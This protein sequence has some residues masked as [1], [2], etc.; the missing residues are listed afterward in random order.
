MGEVRNTLLNVYIFSGDDSDQHFQTY[1]NV[2]SMLEVGNTI[3]GCMIVENDYPQYAVTID[4]II[5]AFNL[6]EASW[7]REEK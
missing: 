5:G 4:R 1:P 3:Y 6:M 7:I 2:R